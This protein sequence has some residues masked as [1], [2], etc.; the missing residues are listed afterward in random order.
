[1]MPLR[2]YIVSRAGTINRL[3]L[4]IGKLELRVAKL[5]AKVGAKKKKKPEA[6]GRHA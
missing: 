6:R 4:A 3:A 5:E 1:M 2:N